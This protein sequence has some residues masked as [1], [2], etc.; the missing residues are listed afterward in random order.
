MVTALG[1][2]NVRAVE[3][4]GTRITPG[5]E[6]Y[7]KTTT[8]GDLDDR[9]A[10][11]VPPVDARGVNSDAARRALADRQRCRCPSGE[12]ELH[13]RAVGRIRPIDVVRVDRDLRKDPRRE[14]D[15]VTLSP[16]AHSAE[17]IMT[18]GAAVLAVG[19][20]IDA[21]PRTLGVAPRACAATTR[22]GTER[23][24]TCLAA[25][26]AVHCVRARVRTRSGTH[27]SETALART[28]PARAC[29]LSRAHVPTGPTV[30]GIRAGVDTRR[31]TRRPGVRAVAPTDCACDP[32]RTRLAAPTT[33]RGIARG[34]DAA[35]GTCVGLRART[36][37]SLA[38]V[39][40][41]R[42]RRPIL[43]RHQPAHPSSARR[44]LA[45][46]P[47]RAVRR[48][49][50]VH[51]R[52]PVPAHIA[53]P[54]LARQPRHQLAAG[55]RASHRERRAHQPGSSRP[56]VRPLRCLHLT[57]SPAPRRPSSPPRL[58]APPPPSRRSPMTPSSSAS[59]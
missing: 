53:E 7:T 30:H 48:R 41:T 44:R 4:K 40:S 27:R 55:P 58:P 3:S 31:S 56:R 33:V 8:D 1:P 22:A 49:R 50:A 26:A 57:T 21:R 23:C 13:D 42:T 5:C 39:S 43:H 35:A 45:L 15:R 51:R 28:V 24:R 20:D 6:R 14:C 25:L 32:C 19:H 29:R 34:I 17:T 54:R 47:R 2:V 16:L 11:R 38:R 46:V 12:G 9:S 18:A 10:A 52:A 36:L 59:P 37:P